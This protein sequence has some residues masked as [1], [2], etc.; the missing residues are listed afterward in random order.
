MTSA[1]GVV[2][3]VVGLGTGA[4]LAPQ[5]VSRRPV[6]CRLL[7]R[8]SGF[9][10]PNH[11][12]LTFDDGPD[13]ASTPAILDGLDEFGWKATFFMLGS[14]VDRHPGVAKEVADRGHEV[15]VHGYSHVSH[16]RRTPGDLRVDIERARQLVTEASGQT[17]IYFRP[18]HGSMAWGSWAG[19]RRAGL[20]TVLWSAWGR[21]WRP[22][23]SP[24]EVVGDVA[25]QLSPGAT[26]L[27]HDSDCTSAAQCWRAAVGALPG[28]AELFARQGLE[29]GPLRDHGLDHRGG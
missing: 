10:R 17:P 16:L 9:G 21:D 28:L 11:V 20:E 29:V 3:A 4:V 6:R 25:R 7:P 2:A 24:S 14:M 22:N 18:P 8:L 13:G 19:A 26:V 5:L 12:A 23:L 15:A 1:R 27:L